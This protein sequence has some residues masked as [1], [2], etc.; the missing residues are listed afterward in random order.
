MDFPVSSSMWIR[1]KRMVRSVPSDKRM[2][3]PPP[4]QMGVV[5]WVI[6]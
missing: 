6:W 5:S 2:F 3:T 1:V 4:V